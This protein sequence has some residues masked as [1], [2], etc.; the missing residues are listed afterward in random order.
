ML[1]HLDMM[2]NLR[3]SLLWRVPSP[4]F[5]FVLLAN[6]NSKIEFPHRAV[7]RGCRLPILSRQGRK[8]FLSP[9]PRRSELL[10]DRCAS[11]RDRHM[12]SSA[13]AT[14]KTLAGA[15]GACLCSSRVSFP[16]LFSSSLLCGIVCNT[17]FELTFLFFSSDCAN[18]S[19]SAVWAVGF[20]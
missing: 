4:L 6:L 19:F 14:M 2:A 17:S 13:A 8:D 11:S 7:R 10:A 5:C 3:L 9:R 16:S 20:T 15:I 18:L 1:S 12:H